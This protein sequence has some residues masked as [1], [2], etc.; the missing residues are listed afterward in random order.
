MADHPAKQSA[1]VEEV[2]SD[3]AFAI[4]RQIVAGCSAIRAAWVALA[5]FLHEFH[6]EQ[7]WEDLGHENF[8]EWLGSPEISL[9]RSHV[10]ALIQ[11]YQVLIVE[12][13][14]EAAKLEAIE[15][16]KAVQVLPALK[17]GEVEVEEALA[18]AES[19]SR[20]DLREKYG[21]RLSASRRQLVECER[22][23]LMRQPAEP[24]PGED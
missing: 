24:P 1:T 22:C 17:R 2:R 16:T 9:G 14:I 5:A 15:A 10:Y 21:K 13:G 12:R 19:L 7:M 11:C 20:I 8:D 18:D 23:G 3:R 4:E 6:A